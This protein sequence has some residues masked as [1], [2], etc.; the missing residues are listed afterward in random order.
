MRKALVGTVSALALATA[1]HAA[2]ST[3]TVTQ[4]G[5]AQNATV[6]QNLGS[7]E[8]SNL[9][10]SGGGNK[11]TINQQ[12]SNNKV[13]TVG[14]AVSQTAPGTG[15]A[16]TG[17]V[18]D[19]LQTGNANAV[20]GGQSANGASADITQTGER[21]TSDHSQT[22]DATAT[23]VQ[24]GDDGTSDVTQSAN[25]AEANVTQN[26]GAS[27]ANS[28]VSQSGA[29]AIA[30]VTQNGL[31]D[32]SRVTQSGA[33]A[34]AQV[35]QTGGNYADGPRS[36][37]GTG[38][39]ASTDPLGGRRNQRSVI[40]QSGAD[41]FA[42]VGQTGVL[43]YSNVKQTADATAEVNQSGTFNISQVE[44]RANGAE[45]TV[46]QGGGYGDNESHILQASTATGAVAEVTQ[47]SDSN[48]LANP[49]NFSDVVQAAANG[50]ATVTQNGDDN[51][52]FTTQNAGATGAVSTIYQDGE[53]NTATVTQDA[54]GAKSNVEQGGYYNL[55]VNQNNLATVRQQAGATNAESDI[56]QGGDNNVTD[57]TQNA[58]NAG[59][60]AY[61]K[62]FGNSVTVEQQ[63]SGNLSLIVQRNANVGGEA[64]N[65]QATVRQ[66]AGSTN[67][68]S[69][70]GQEGAAN[71][72]QVTMSGATAAK[73]GGVPS[74]NATVINYPD[75]QVWQ[76]GT[77]NQAYVNQA[78]DNA[79]T[80]VYQGVYW[81][82]TPPNYGLRNGSANNRADVAQTADGD[83][84]DS[85]VYQ[86]GLGNQATVTQA[87]LNG[88]SEIRQ[89]GALN[90]ATLD[91]QS[92][93]GHQST[94]WQLAD[95]NT[96]T[97]IQS[98]LSNVAI[99]NQTTNGNT[100]NVTQ[101]GTGGI[102]TVNQ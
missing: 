63:A 89:D 24:D 10:Q 48:Q 92:G 54:A 46:T 77:N 75:S 59:S 35:T 29:G 40:D 52:A 42:K 33:G 62:G 79:T 69:Y 88:W 95:G 36:E 99:V 47:T 6:N 44:Q 73:S 80:V 87:S 66:L 70:V 78:A 1:A 84:S 68:L 26:S 45:A 53:D 8:F 102:A 61:T 41:A 38:T 100:S 30:T 19:V 32:D 14:T 2:D 58:A 23:V 91:Q 31:Y 27:G 15:S 71:I 64:S 5:T 85:T 101:T 56:N 25:N 51:Y 82:P 16:N 74:Y 3:S 72:A 43:N 96:A 28:E 83:G 13:G 67:A 97:T 22:A 98:G 90:T 37:T 65:N 76:I 49:S 93:S 57:I 86:G 39:R 21:N 7:N 17:A 81:N 11:A 20:T 60:Y 4:S 9:S 18:L 50:Q 34:E 55:P 12:G 94:I